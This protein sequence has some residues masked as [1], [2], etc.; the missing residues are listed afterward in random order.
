[1][2]VDAALTRSGTIGI[3]GAV[4]RDQDGAFLGASAIVWWGISDPTTLEALA[5]R[6]DLALAD[7]L[8]VQ[9]IQVASDC[10]VVFDDIKQGS[11]AVC[12]NHLGD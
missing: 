6:E 5:M 3:V 9:Q 12:G 7:D 2:N 10:K 11:A 4:S 1:M 8:Y